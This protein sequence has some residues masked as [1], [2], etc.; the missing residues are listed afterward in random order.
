[1]RVSTFSR[2]FSKF[3]LGGVSEALARALRNARQDVRV[4]LPWTRELDTSS[5]GELV[6]LLVGTD[7]E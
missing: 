5:L 4:F 2:S 6:E 7:S 1:M 3:S